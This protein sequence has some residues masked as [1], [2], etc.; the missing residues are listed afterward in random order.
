MKIFVLDDE[1]HT[2]EGIV[3]QLGIEGHSIVFESLVEDAASWLSNL[4]NACDVLVLDIMMISEPTFQMDVTKDGLRTG[5]EFFKF[6]RS[7]RPCLPVVVLT[8]SAESEVEEFFSKQH[9]CRYFQKEDF[10]VS[11]AGYI[12]EKFVNSCN[13]G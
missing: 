4:Q 1:M 13:K 7:L 5:V 10:T 12:L 11:D 6:V 2:I 9:A 3:L 8:N